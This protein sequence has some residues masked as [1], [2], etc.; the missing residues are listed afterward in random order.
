MASIT[1]IRAITN[2][3]N[4]AFAKLGQTVV[5]YSCMNVRIL[6]ILVRESVIQG[7]QIKGNDIIVALMN[8]EIA[9]QKLKNIRPVSK[10]SKQVYARLRVLKHV[11]ARLGV[12]INSLTLISTNS[13]V[14]T[15]AEAVSEGLGG[16]VLFAANTFVIESIALAK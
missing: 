14:T 16:E 3:R 15:I 6:D 8:S 5:K 12:S 4:A 2:I 7:F 10:P 9:R 13:G 1:S 11:Y